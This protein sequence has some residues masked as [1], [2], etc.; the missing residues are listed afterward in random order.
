LGLFIYL[1]ALRLNFAC[2]MVGIQF[3]EV[4]RPNQLLVI[5]D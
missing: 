4:T 3:I 2:S 5:N 1:P